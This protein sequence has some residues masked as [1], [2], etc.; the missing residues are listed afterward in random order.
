MV[1]RTKQF[2]V[3]LLVFASVLVFLFMI[4]SVGSDKGLLS[5]SHIIFARYN[6]VQGLK[7]GAPVHLAG[8]Q[9]GYVDDVS[10]IPT[11][12]GM[13]VLLTLKIN[14][15]Y[16]FMVRR[17]S[18]AKIVTQGVLGDKYIQITLGAVESPELQT[19]DFVK[20]R[21]QASVIDKLG[22]GGIFDRLE[23]V[24]ISL[25]DVLNEFTE[26]DKLVKIV[27]NLEESAKNLK[28]ATSRLTDKKTV[29][30]QLLSK[31]HE[32][33][34]QLV[35]DSLKDVSDSMSHVVEKIDDGTGTIGALINDPT[36]Y[37]DLK[38]LLGGAKRNA[39]L[40]FVVRESLKKAEAP[41]GGH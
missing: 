2:A 36:L 31:D 39:L 5:R 28:S 27:D 10:F 9:V 13:E 20:A 24:L 26:G 32:G 18:V 23:T 38:I 19:G 22:E 37:E 7:T 25:S 11:E 40:K 8:I 21:E 30:G 12:T 41:S 34:I 16:F 14:H 15:K 6:H 33:K 17:D 4:F 3:G 29:I 35:I 1:D